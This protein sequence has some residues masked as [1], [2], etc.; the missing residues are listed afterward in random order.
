MCGFIG[1]SEYKAQLFTTTV[2]IDA[3]TTESQVKPNG[4]NAYSVPELK[5]VRQCIARFMDRFVNNSSPSMNE[6]FQ[7]IYGSTCSAPLKRETS[8][9]NE[10][11]LFKNATYKTEYS[12][13]ES[14]D[15]TF[16][17]NA[18]KKF[19]CSYYSG[20]YQETIKTTIGI[21]VSIS[22]FYS[23][24]VK[25]EMDEQDRT[26]LDSSLMHLNRMWKHADDIIR[27]RDAKKI[28]D[29]RNEYCS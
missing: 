11:D 9:E 25:K 16:R 10:F 26:L 8:F 1:G 20:E 13:M 17:R 6:L 15:P 7:S 22:H 14:D 3:M 28:A 2:L 4:I 23:R 24:R 18:A 21:L 5:R 19:I 12:Q 29:I 27:E